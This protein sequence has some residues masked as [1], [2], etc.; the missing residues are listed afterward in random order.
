LTWTQGN[1][2]AFDQI[3]RIINC[4][5][6]E[7]RS[8]NGGGAL[9]LYGNGSPIIFNSIF[10]NNFGESLGSEI[11]D[12]FQIQGTKIKVGHS[13]LLWNEND[14]QDLA[15]ESIYALPPAFVDTT[16]ENF[17]LSNASSLIG[18]GT[19]SY[20]GVDA[21]TK[22]IQGNM[23]PNP[24][25]SSPDLGAY[26]NSLAESPFPSQVK[27]VTATIGSQSVSLSWDA[28]SETDIKK[29]LIYMSQ[30]SGFEPTSEDN[31]GESA[32]S[33]FSATGLTNNTE[34]HFQ[35]A[36]VDSSGYRG[37]FSQEISAIPEYK[38]PVWWV[39]DV[40]GSDN[41]D[42]SSSSPLLN[43]S[44]AV[45]MAAAGDTIKLLPG[46]YGNDNLN[47][48][49]LLDKSISIIGVGG[50]DQT[51]IDANGGSVHFQMNGASVI[52][53]LKGIQFTNGYDNNNQ[54]GGSLYV[55]DIDS[56]IVTNCI[57][58]NNFSNQRAGVMHL[59]KTESVFRNV[60]FIN[61]GVGT[62]NDDQYVNAGVF[63]VGG[64]EENDK[65]YT[66]K[67]IECIF[68]NNGVNTSGSNSSGSAGIFEQQI[69]GRAVF[70]DSQFK[71]N[72]VRAT[73]SN[74][75]AEG[76]IFRA[77]HG[78]IQSYV[79]FPTGSNQPYLPTVFNRCVFKN[80]YL[81]A[82]GNKMGIL[83]NTPQPLQVINCLFVDNYAIGNDDVQGLFRIDPY[84]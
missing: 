63:N 64:G 61:N 20:L 42:G 60:D 53:R 28:N 75:W 36:A 54:W 51:I 30:A 11:L 10:L 43:I 25:G 48:D 41:G 71:N 7:N 46:N 65:M 38:G 49:I 66:A 70:I 45:T 83:F 3:Q 80:N 1:G 39:D 16:K 2:G 29:Y 26:E 84:N 67:F 52:V 9:S 55:T 19:T 68:E 72:Y 78:N 74:S 8:E 40:N 18:L 77:N 5:F 24:S 79:D 21:P 14:E 50:P 69:G 62:N 81:E 44:S 6:V 47:T 57:F 37:A 22:D 23:R 59:H 82:S 34:Y 15:Y 58:T 17:N 73:G 35:V 12:N 76:S 33:S 32:T 4:T 13:S 27:N 31:I 56:L